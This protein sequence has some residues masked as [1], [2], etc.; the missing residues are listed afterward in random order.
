MKQALEE[1]IPQSPFKETVEK[2]QVL[3]YL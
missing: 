2:C 3:N 1:E